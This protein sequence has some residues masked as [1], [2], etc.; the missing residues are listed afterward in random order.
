M[1]LEREI[2]FAI[3]HWCRIFLIASWRPQVSITVLIQCSGHHIAVLVYF[4]C[5][6]WIF[7][8]FNLLDDSSRCL[9]RCY[10]FTLVAARHARAW[11]ANELLRTDISALNLQDEPIFCRVA[12]CILLARSSSS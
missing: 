1:H 9:L 5:L 11:L 10:D 6:M 4:D 7:F 8:L 12:L 3:A 2:V